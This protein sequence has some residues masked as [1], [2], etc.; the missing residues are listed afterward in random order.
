MNNENNSSFLKEKIIRVPG[1]AAGG[2]HSLRIVHGSK[3][4]NSEW[5][6]GEWRVESELTI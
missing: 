3:L 5:L 2:G 6:I 1:E 4:Q